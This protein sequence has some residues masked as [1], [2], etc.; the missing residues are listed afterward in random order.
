M[1]IHKLTLLAILGC[2]RAAIPVL[3]AGRGDTGT[4][5]IHRLLCSM[6]IRSQHYRNA[7]NFQGVQVLPGN[8]QECLVQSRLKEVLAYFNSIRKKVYSKSQQKLSMQELRSLRMALLEFS[9]TGGIEPFGTV[10]VH[11]APVPFFINDLVRFNPR[12]AVVHLIH[13][14]ARVWV[15]RRFHSGHGAHD[16]ICQPRWWSRVQ[17]PFDVSECYD[18]GLVLG[19]SY[20]DMFMTTIAL[21]ST[22]PTM[23]PLAYTKYVKHIRNMV[24]PT[25]L[26]EIDI[27]ACTA[28][29]YNVDLHLKLETQP[30]NRK[31]CQMD[32]VGRVLQEFFNWNENGSLSR[33]ST[34]VTAASKVLAAARSV[35][36]EMC[37]DDPVRSMER[38]W[39][40]DARPNVLAN[41]SPF[42]R[43]WELTQEMI[44][45]TC[46][47]SR[48]PYSGRV[49]HVCPQV[50]TRNVYQLAQS[51]ERYQRIAEKL[52]SQKIMI[53]YVGDSVMEQQCDAL[54]CEFPQLRAHSRC[55]AYGTQFLVPPVP[56]LKRNPR[57]YLPA[58]YQP[59]TA[60]WEDAL[61]NATHV[62]L[63]TGLWWTGIVQ[64]THQNKLRFLHEDQNRIVEGYRQSLDALS[65]VVARL[66][67]RGVD[68]IWRDTTPT[69]IC[70]TKDG[71][72]ITKPDRYTETYKCIPELNAIAQ[73]TIRKAGGRVLPIYTLSLR[74]PSIERFDTVHFCM[75]DA[76]HSVPSVWN[77]LLLG[78]IANHAWDHETHA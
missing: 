30:A 5:V 25:Q 49:K 31:L 63:N 14:P 33:A 12:A 74:A 42:S 75:E 34:L 61:E 20:G 36:N 11:D 66:V 68:V 27:F 77:K 43:S 10:A 19:K 35:P 9:K 55:Y 1:L 57:F 15:Q 7:C 62:V 23:L 2:A 72:H 69:G 3:G 73:E 21:N 47:R 18:A 13:L 56:W 53:Y 50:R 58:A 4:T 39:T 6:G 45:K 51:T 67:A 78:M 26:L 16:I 70:I 24:A 37:S 8:C 76:S 60:L 59:P 38:S 17:N 28:I 48:S 40:T 71:R 29:H 22:Q 54:H 32:S 41:D 44:N 46:N 64:G 52:A 65:P